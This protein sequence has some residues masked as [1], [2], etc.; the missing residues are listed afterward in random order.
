[1]LASSLQLLS[2]LFGRI[3]FFSKTCP[4]KKSLKNGSFSTAS[5]SPHPP[6]P[7]SSPIPQSS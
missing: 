5:F 3:D 1:V 2:S 6:F 4:C 7:S